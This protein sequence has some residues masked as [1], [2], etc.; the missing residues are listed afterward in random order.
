MT[1]TS[2]IRMHRFVV[3]MSAALAALRV[4]VAAPGT[5]SS[6]SNHDDDDFDL[7]NSLLLGMA[8]K[9][10]EKTVSP[11]N[12]LDLTISELECRNI[13]LHD[14]TFS[15]ADGRQQEEGEEVVDIEIGL[16]VD[17]T[18]TFDWIYTYDPPLIAP[19]SS[20]GRGQIDTKDNAMSTTLV[21]SS[22]DFS[23]EGPVSSTISGCN[24]NINVKN[25][26]FDGSISAAIINSVEW[27]IRGIVENEIEGALCEE[28]GALG[29]V[30]SEQLL[31]I[32]ALVEP[33]LSEDNSDRL[34]IDPL[35][36]EK[37]LKDDGAIDLFDFTQTEGIVE[38]GVDAGIRAIDRR[39]G[40]LVRDEA[41]K[42]DLGINVLLRKYFLDGDGYLSLPI[43]AI[44]IF[45]EFDV[46]V[47]DEVS[48]VIKSIRVKGLDSFTSID[49]LK[50]LSS[51]TLQTRFALEYLPL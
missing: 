4:A 30:V 19:L 28:L 23:V 3:L 43:N 34:P 46:F 35:S 6:L 12:S 26:E 10:P 22:P 40:D 5:A 1:A 45:H 50:V 47:L 51:Q 39:L 7:L 16:E 17:M 29:D 33:Y 48:V 32:K 38:Y 49:A 41:G 44:P 42:Q 24:P 15:H 11:M 8:L 20:G 31:S 9:L 14:I 25:M 2:I 36:A 21:F 27:A 18:C 13:Y 37:R